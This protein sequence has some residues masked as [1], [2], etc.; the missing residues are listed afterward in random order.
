ML[1]IIKTNLVLFLL[2][3]GIN[4][5]ILAFL[6]RSI[7]PIHLSGTQPLIFDL[8]Q[9][10][11]R[12]PFFGVYIANL[13]NHLLIWLIGRRLFSPKQSLLPVLIFACS[14]WSIYLTV[15]QS[16]NI[17]LLCF[18]LMQIL[19]IIYIRIKKISLGIVVSTVGIILTLYSSLLLLSIYL[20]ILNL[21][22]FSLINLRRIKLLLLIVLILC[23][24][25]VYSSIKNIIGVKNIYLN[26][27]NIYSD[28]G[29]LA[30]VNKLQGES[31][32]AHLGVISRIAEN[33]YAYIGEYTILKIFKNLAPATYFT[34]QEKLLGFS[35]SPPILVGFMIPFL[36]GLFS[37]ISSMKLRNY[38]L[39]ST[40][41]IAPSILSKSLVNLNRLLL[42]EPVIAVISSYGLI[43]LNQNKSKR[44]FLYLTIFLVVLQ[45][46]VTVFDIN[47]RDFFRYERYFGSGFEIGNQ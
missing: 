13:L 34:A 25:L 46:L 29:L 17:I 42:F 43:N 23:L 39:L 44:F 36:Y 21:V 37:I 6:I 35:F 8:L 2:I 24:P 9:V 7:Y 3:I 20:I 16:F 5:I 30:F 27:V 26:Q 10:N 31:R 4:H 19:G 11:V 15:A 28:P 14:P 41:L 38:F 22:M 32:K 18:I 12:I 1:R 45:L 40:I 47:Q 33:K